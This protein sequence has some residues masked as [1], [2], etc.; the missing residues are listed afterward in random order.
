MIGKLDDAAMDRIDHV[1]AATARRSRALKV[2]K[3]SSSPHS[4][5]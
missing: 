4:R 1:I 3:S 5:H 2:S